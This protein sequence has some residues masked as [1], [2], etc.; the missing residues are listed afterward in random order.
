MHNPNFYGGHAPL[1]MFAK[2][3]QKKQVWIPQFTKQNG[4]VVGGHFAHVHVTDDHDD[5]KVAS[6]Q[7]SHS[8][9]KAHAALSA[10]EPH[11]AGMSPADKAALIM[12]HATQIQDGESAA[13]RLATLR[14]KLLGGSAP[15]PGEWKHF[16]AAPADKKEK[17]TADVQEAG[18]GDLMATL[19]AEWEAKQPAAPQEAPAK[20][21]EPKA[22]GKAAP[23]PEK[24]ATAPEIKGEGMASLERLSNK[25]DGLLNDKTAESLAELQKIEASLTHL[26]P[27]LKPEAQFAADGLLNYLS[28]GIEEGKAALEAA[29]KKAAEEKAADLPPA[30]K[31]APQAD[32]GGKETAAPAKPAD[33]VKLP[34]GAPAKPN[35]VGSLSAKAVVDAIEQ[36]MAEGSLAKLDDAMG[37]VPMTSTKLKWQKVKD[38]AG[39]AHAFIEQQIKKQHDEAFVAEA[40]PEKPTITPGGKTEDLDLP[41]PQFPEGLTGLLAYATN[42]KVGLHSMSKST[43]RQSIKEIE[44]ALD[45]TTPAPESNAAKV[46]AYGH[47]AVAF[48]KAMQK[49]PKLHEKMKAAKAAEK[50]AKADASP[51]EG[52]TKEGVG[53]T[54]VL[55]DGHWILQGAIGAPAAD[56]M[57]ESLD[58]PLLAKEAAE[59]WLAANPGKEAELSAA[60]VDVVGLAS[61]AT[62]MGI[63]PAAAAAPAPAAQAWEEAATE[64]TKIAASAHATQELV[65]KLHDAKVALSNTNAKS[66]NPKV[67]AIV[68]ALEAGDA[69]ALLGMGFGTNTYGKKAAKLANDALAHLGSSHTVT[70]GQKAGAHAGLQDAA[71]APAAEVTEQLDTATAKLQLPPDLEG[72]FEIWNFANTLKLQP[73]QQPGAPVSEWVDGEDMAAYEALDQ[74]QK[75]ALH[76]AIIAH[77]PAGA[78][79]QLKAW[80]DWHYN[81][82]LAT[83]LP[84]VPEGVAG[85][86][87]GACQEALAAAKKGDLK[88]L[89]IMADCCNEMSVGTKLTD[90]VNT[91]VAQV[92]AAGPTPP[93]TTGMTATVMGSLQDAIDAFKA[94][95]LHKLGMCKFN[96]AGFEKFAA[97]EKYIDEAMAHLHAS[98]APA[99]AAPAVPAALSFDEFLTQVPNVPEIPSANYTALKNMVTAGNHKNVADIVANFK[100][101]G[102]ITGKIAEVA[103][104]A[105]N[106]MKKKAGMPVMT[107]NPALDDPAA[108]GEAGAA[109]EQGPKDGDTKQGADG[110]LVFQNGRWHKM[111]TDPKVLAQKAKSVPIPALS[112]KYAINM[113][114]TMKA[115]QA[116][117]AAEGATGLAK[118]V[119]VQSDGK[120]K[121][122]KGAGNLKSWVPLMPGVSAG[123]GGN[124]MAMADYAKALLGAMEGTKGSSAPQAP[125]PA[126]AAPKAAPKAAAPAAATI[127]TPT[128]EKV[129]KITAMVADK[130]E[131]TGPQKGSNPGGKFKDAKG[132]EWYCKFPSDP[133]TVMNELLAAKFYQMLGS[134]VPE[135]RLVKKDGKLGIASKWVDGMKKGT[136]DELASAPGAHTGFV[137]DAWL[138]NWDVVGLSNDNLLLG[139]DGKALRVDVGGSLL[140]RAQGGPK[141]AAFGENVTELDSLLDAG[142]NPQSA[143]VFKNVTTADLEAGASVLA[144]MHPSQI[145]KLCVTFGPGTRPEQEDLAAKL[146][147]RR[148]YILDKLGIA[149]P[150]NVAPLDKTALPVNPADMPPPIDFSNYQG[151]GKGLSSKEH[152][153]KQNTIDD[154]ALIEFAKKGNLKALQEYHYDAYDKVSGAY[155]GKKPIGEHPSKDIKN[156]HA[157]LCDLLSAVA[158][159]PVQGLDLPPIGGGSIEEVSE[160]AGYV[161]PGEN[162]NTVSS[163][164]VVGYWM[165]LGHV[166]ADA[167]KDLMPAKTSFLTKD[168]VAKAKSWYKGV[169]EPTKALVNT[170]L[171]SG[172]G[173]RFWNE[174]KKHIKLNSYKHTYDGG[175]QTLASTIYQEAFEFEE[176]QTVGR[177]MNLP[178]TMKEQL[179]KE[180]AGLV[181]QNADSM[182]ASIFKD[183]GNN[184]K[185][186]SGAFVNIRFAKGAK[187]MASLGCG[188]FSSS[189]TNADGEYIHAGGGGE[190]EVT[191]LMGQRFVVLEVKKGN[192][193]SPNGI[194]LELLALPPHE[195]YVAELGNMAALGKS[196]T[197]GA[198]ALR[199]MVLFFQPVESK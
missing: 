94:G 150:W 166:G 74:N 59:A 82:D 157:S 129:G 97:V 78:G 24:A 25:I 65:N 103:E 178:D 100:G 4:Q 197:L 87:L 121:I 198:N 153:N 115:L 7:G 112:G 54:L 138:A 156:H 33:P 31:A 61:I 35:I 19:Y 91:L 128:I 18:H 170:I 141:G 57:K 55:K 5:H 52:D 48:I 177:W 98:A 167:V 108:D 12:H 159:P 88:T 38:Y 84:P 133:D 196:L 58:G 160:A 1:L 190:M 191:T 14:K 149:D 28:Q 135:L 85:V 174:G 105:L 182:C 199:K 164:K 73:K 125:A 114:Q 193:S 21:A 46:L 180:G 44:G 96:V 90:Y 126:A 64:K 179:L 119:K 40:Q 51:H 2:A 104:V 102:G 23:E 42:I 77:D 86:E 188:R 101:A 27:E 32:A 146:V 189:N 99:P 111:G 163:D 41:Y 110:M 37:D 168:F 53:G 132:Q 137:F 93:S 134:P 16:H 17:I 63:A 158:H 116:L 71:P 123:V 176:G 142:K 131:Q 184:A 22:E 45:G 26:L 8:Q 95:D 169:S 49:N 181:L 81:K 152:I 80:L 68:A 171:D 136:A 195:G 192:A 89:T 36:A 79:E 162:I 106:A 194:T 144:K 165:K 34:A 183:W 143:A 6:G 124:A 20:A 30:P 172:A 9:K 83:A 154:A 161:K 173:N 148:Q 10:E 185:F 15:T 29:G 117:A 3:T 151:T 175:A 113:K 11:F 186:G 39:K 130:W 140:F 60:L 107:G 122:N 69:K 75:V 62:E 56:F 70:A 47:A 72:N 147:A 127:A 43:I 92:K 67:D 109:A 145:K 66:F 13:A 139:A 120:I 76:A 118:I 187:A 50:A 155:L